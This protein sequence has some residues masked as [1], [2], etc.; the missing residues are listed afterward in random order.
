MPYFD[1]VITY[2]AAP[3]T[4]LP[5]L[6][7]FYHLTCIHLLGVV[8]NAHV[9]IWEPEPLAAPLDWKLVTAVLLNGETNHKDAFGFA[10]LIPT[11]AGLAASAIV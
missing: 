8:P 3:Y 10:F 1:K 4:L 11:L 6:K 2:K 5:I 9:L 7:E